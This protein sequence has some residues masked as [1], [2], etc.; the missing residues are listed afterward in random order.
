MH[1]SR[2]HPQSPWPSP[3]GHG[4]QRSAQNPL[5]A[6]RDAQS[7][8]EGWPLRA[9]PRGQKVP[10][11]PASSLSLNTPQAP[12]RPHLP[13]TGPHY[14]AYNA[15][16]TVPP[17]WKCAK[18]QTYH[19]PAVT[20][21]VPCHQ[22]VTN[23]PA[24][25]CRHRPAMTRSPLPQVGTELDDATGVLAP[26]PKPAPRGHSSRGLAPL[27][28]VTALSWSHPQRE[29]AGTGWLDLPQG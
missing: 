19:I 28:G 11:S 2:P 21:R 15:E 26:Q 24:L 14:P 3:V 22:R 4:G 1:C 25:M 29:R 10:N 7:C 6:H 27:P 16:A 20:P 18:L 13:L 17:T 12:S 5:L 9:G 8:D 23:P